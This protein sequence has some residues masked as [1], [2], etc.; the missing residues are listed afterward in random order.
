MI[1]G[2]NEK[3]TERPHSSSI[4]SP[5]ESL[6][7]SV[8][9]KYLLLH[10]TQI[11]NYY[12]YYN[13]YFKAITYKCVHS[14]RVFYY[15]SSIYQLHINYLYTTYLQP[16]NY[17]SSTYQLPINYL[18]ITYQ[19]PITFIISV[20]QIF[21]AALLPINYLLTTYLLHTYILP[22]NYL[23]NTYQLPTKIIANFFFLFW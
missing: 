17:L 10:L 12:K 20:L 8:F 11:L 9:C 6:S 1:V 22:I 13:R 2:L 21:I 4:T 7:S 23:S 16:I 14:P 18:S 15:L 19:L 3:I 5:W